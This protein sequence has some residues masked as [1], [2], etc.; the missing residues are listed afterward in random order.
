MITKQGLVQLYE[1]A[2]FVMRGESE[3]V[4]G[5]DTWYEMGV[6]FAE[7]EGEGEGEEALAVKAEEEEE[8]EGE[9]RNPGK[10]LGSRAVGSIEAVVDKETGLNSADLF[11][12]RAECRCL[13]LRKGAGKFVRGH[14]S[15]FEVSFGVL[16]HLLTFSAMG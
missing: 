10:K 9:V 6:D 13:L 8:D 2:G 16:L 15:D 5:K 14:K 12:P 11:C 7:V 4:H 3:V 1:K